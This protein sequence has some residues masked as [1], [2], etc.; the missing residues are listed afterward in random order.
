MTSADRIKSGKVYQVVVDNLRQNLEAIKNYEEVCVF[1]I[2]RLYVVNGVI[3]QTESI[4]DSKPTKSV[5][6]HY[7]RSITRTA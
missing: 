7:K 1:L 6:Y 5:S 4:W 3:S 2:L